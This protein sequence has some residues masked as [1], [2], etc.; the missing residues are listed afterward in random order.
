MDAPVPKTSWRFTKRDIAISATVALG[1][2]MP[3][4]AW[5]LSMI[6][7]L[8]KASSVTVVLVF[9]PAALLLTHGILSGVVGFTVYFAVQFL[10]WAGWTLLV[11]RLVYGT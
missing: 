2:G 4:S 7:A 6:G 3:V 10:W 5:I 1:L 8:V 11:R 9:A